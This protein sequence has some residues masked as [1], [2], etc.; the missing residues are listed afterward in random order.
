MHDKS[1]PPPSA[2]SLVGD[3]DD[4]SGNSHPRACAH[5]PESSSTMRQT[6]INNA[7]GRRSLRPKLNVKTAAI[8][9]VLVFCAVYSTL[10]DFHYQQMYQRLYSDRDVSSFDAP[11]LEEEDGQNTSLGIGAQDNPQQVQQE[12]VQQNNT[13]DSS[14]YATSSFKVDAYSFPTVQERLQYYMGDWFNKTGWSVPDCNLVKEEHNHSNV[15]FDEVRL[16]TTTT[17]KQCMFSGLSNPNSIGSTYCKDAYSFINTT[18]ASRRGRDDAAHW[19]FGFGDRIA[20]L[21]NQLPI[22]TKARPSLL[23]SDHPK[24]PLWLLNKNRHYGELDR[25]HNEV[26]RGE[27][28]EVPWS[29]K[30]PKLFWRGSTTGNRAGQAG[31][32]LDFLTQWVHHNDEKIDIGFNNIVAMTS[33]FQREYIE[34]YYSKKGKEAEGRESLHD[35]NRYKYLLSIEGNDVASGLK[36]MLYSNSVVFMARPTV[37]TWAME[38]LLIPFVHYIPVANDYSNLLAMVHWAEEHDDACQEISRRATEYIEHLWIS[39]QA[40]R[41]TEMLQKAM[42]TMYTDQFDHALSE[43]SKTAE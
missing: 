3:G 41:D 42:A 13:K 15:V 28:G 12:Q 10:L 6:P 32:R 31:H 27:K 38:D 29:E 1:L 17:I 7:S 11:Q 24:T 20:E 9:S 4:S 23:S 30:I 33:K 25:Y 8:I 40:K 43:C 16:L 18:E 37:A 39:D 2:S 14:Q 36:W 19:L 35:M 22:I 34:R 21:G 26:V 5:L